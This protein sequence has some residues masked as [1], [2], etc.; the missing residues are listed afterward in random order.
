[1]LY[2]LMT[3]RVAL[4]EAFP[5]LADN[6][7][8]CLASAGSSLRLGGRPLPY[9]GT[10]PAFNPSLQHHEEDWRHSKP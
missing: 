5:L 6:L 9:R 10:V 4:G 1:M 7:I 8:L 3:H 2:P